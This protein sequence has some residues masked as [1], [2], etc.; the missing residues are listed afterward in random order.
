MFLG[1]HPTSE[2]PYL[3]ELPPDGAQLGT[4]DGTTLAL[5]RAFYE[6]EEFLSPGTI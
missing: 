3:G 4:E 1:V 6:L 5:V 2:C